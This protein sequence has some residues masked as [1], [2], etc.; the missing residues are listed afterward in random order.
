MLLK[1]PITGVARLEIARD[2]PPVCS[3]KRAA[4]PN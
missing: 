4:S 3:P 2:L 1:K